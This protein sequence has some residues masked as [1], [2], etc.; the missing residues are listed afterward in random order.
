MLISVVGHSFEVL[1]LGPCSILRDFVALLGFLCHYTASTSLR[2]FFIFPTLMVGLSY[3]YMPLHRRSFPYVCRFVGLSLRWW[4]VLVSSRVLDFAIWFR[5]LAG[6]GL[7]ICCTFIF[8]V[9]PVVRRPYL[10]VWPFSV[11]RLS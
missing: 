7:G 2:V 10:D 5:S 1:G 8:F 6:S 4:S 9:L 3:S 11:S